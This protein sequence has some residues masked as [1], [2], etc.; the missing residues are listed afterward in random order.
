MDELKNAVSRMFILICTVSN[1]T[2]KAELQL[3]LQNIVDTF[4]NI[5]TELVDKH[6]PPNP[7]N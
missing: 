2:L 6:N 1:P 4:N 5:V 7:P 3:E